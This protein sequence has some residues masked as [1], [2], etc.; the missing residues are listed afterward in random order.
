MAGNLQQMSFKI[1]TETEPKELLMKLLLSPIG[2]R[3]LGI[4]SLWDWR[5]VGGGTG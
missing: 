5:S 1:R 3:L 2:L 4:V